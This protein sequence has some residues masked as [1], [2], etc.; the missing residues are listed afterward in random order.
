MNWII[1]LYI[2]F[3]ILFFIREGIHDYWVW[4]ASDAKKI[5]ANKRWHNEDLINK[6]LL[7]TFIG[8]TYTLVF[9]LE[10]YYVILYGLYGAITRQLFLNTTINLM[11]GNKIHYF[12]VK[13]DVKLFSEY[14]IISYICIIIAFLFLIFVNIYLI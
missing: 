11:R 14:P 1:S 13:N 8:I 2:I 9:N 12:S 7:F 10:I 3:P 5:A 4:K 6:I